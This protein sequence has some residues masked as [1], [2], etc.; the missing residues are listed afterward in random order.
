MANQE[1]NFL[2]LIRVTKR[3][4]PQQV[5]DLLFLHVLLLL[6]LPYVDFHHRGS[7]CRTVSHQRTHA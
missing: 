1:L 4:I 2:K 6:K 3:I 7:L 5:M